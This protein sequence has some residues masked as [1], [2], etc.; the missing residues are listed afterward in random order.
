MTER[1]APG[2][3]QAPARRPHNFDP[4]GP[5]TWPGQPPL[6][7]CGVVKANAIHDPAKVA[8]FERELHE[9]QAEERRRLGEED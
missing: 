6:C 8:A 4:D 3:V 7:R 2:R 9:G 5:E 1:Y